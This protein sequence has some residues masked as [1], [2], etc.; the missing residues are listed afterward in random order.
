MI[1][2]NAIRMFY[3]NLSVKKKRD[4][5]YLSSFV[6][7]VKIKL[8]SNVLTQILEIPKERITRTFASHQFIEAPNILT[9]LDQ[10]TLAFGRIVD[11]SERII[12]MPLSC[13]MYLL[14]SIVSWIILLKER[15]KDELK[16]MDL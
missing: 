12:V 9:S 13:E 14:H 10:M 7:G 15:Y 3:A 16:F 4:D 2:E 5:I 6:Y 1:Y 8:N 11:D